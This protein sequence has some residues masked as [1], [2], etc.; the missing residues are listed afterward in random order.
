MGE[1][2]GRAPELLA[3]RQQIP[4]HFADGEDLVDHDL[5]PRH[6]RHRR[7]GRMTARRP[8]TG[9]GPASEMEAFDAGRLKS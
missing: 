2:G 7:D 1:I 6:R 4:E 3:G 9:T 5:V 8:T